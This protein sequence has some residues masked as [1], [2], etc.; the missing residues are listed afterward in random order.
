[1]GVVAGGDFFAAI[2]IAGRPGPYIYIYI[3]IMHNIHAYA[4]IV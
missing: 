2:G 1:M 3:Y 4:D